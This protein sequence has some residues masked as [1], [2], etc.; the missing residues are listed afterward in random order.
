M[1]P[2]GIS[3]GANN[4]LAHRSASNSNVAPTIMEAGSNFLL[5]LPN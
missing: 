2:I 3:A 5:S 1:I 4:N